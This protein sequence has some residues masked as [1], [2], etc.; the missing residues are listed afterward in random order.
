MRIFFSLLLLFSSL[1]S[2]QA[3]SKSQVSEYEQELYLNSGGIYSVEDILANEGL[4][5]SQKFRGFMAAHNAHPKDGEKICPVTLTKA[6]PQCT[7]VIAGK[8]YHF[9]CPPCI[10]EFVTLAKNSPHLIK[11]PEEYVKR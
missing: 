1:A 7:W 11:D 8:T 5:P 10:D 2:L 3:A 9:C 4:T 6:N